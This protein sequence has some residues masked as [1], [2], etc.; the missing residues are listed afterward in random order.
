MFTAKSGPQA[1]SI[2]VK[3]DS[4]E[5]C[6]LS[7]RATS[8]REASSSAYDGE[9]GI[10]NKLQEIRIK[11]NEIR[12]KLNEIRIKLNEI[13]IRIKL[14]ILTWKQTAPWR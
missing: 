5:N 14:G 4:S 10:R 8:A 7:S 11:L 9:S 3:K 2:S 12:S 6:P 1:S 13:E